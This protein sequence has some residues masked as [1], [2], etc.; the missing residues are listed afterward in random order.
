MIP[1]IKIRL[2]YMKRH[3]WK[4]FLNYFSAGLM[5]LFILF[6]YLKFERYNRNLS[7]K[8][9]NYHIDK[10]PYNY[11]YYYYEKY[12]GVITDEE[13]IINEFN[14]TFQNSSFIIKKIK[15]EDEISSSNYMAIIEVVKKGDLYKFKLKSNSIS[16]SKLI[17]DEE[18]DLI[19]PTRYYGGDNTILSNLSFY[20]HKIL[21][22]L[23]GKQS[24]KNLIVYSCRMLSSDET[25]SFITSELLLLVPIWGNFSFNFIKND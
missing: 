2:T 17:S 8:Y 10:F 12:I 11:T 9:P 25:D 7:I 4:C 3:P 5:M 21:L 6:S 22:N 24:V 23:N 16:V 1:L 14:K 20:I 19:L 13:R 15:N 18:S